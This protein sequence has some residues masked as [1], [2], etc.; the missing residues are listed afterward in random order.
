MDI[1]LGDVAALVQGQVVGDAATR[2]FSLA[3]IDNIV[4]GSLVFAEGTDK[5]QTAEASEAGAIIVHKKVALS[6]KPL[7]Q[8]DH[9]LKAF[10]QLIQHFHPPSDCTG[11]SIGGRSNY[12][13]LCGY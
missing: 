12:R 2:V 1:S 10:I 8:V 5:I 6:I 3:S 9:P 13:P 4:T 7:I 11:G